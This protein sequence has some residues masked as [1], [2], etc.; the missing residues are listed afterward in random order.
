MP[1]SSRPADLLLVGPC[2]TD[3]STVAY[4]A[5]TLKLFVCVHVPVPLHNAS[6]LDVANAW[7]FSPDAPSCSLSPNEKSFVHSGFFFCSLTADVL[8]RHSLK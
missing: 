1:L 8:M 4:L 7:S 5:I 6:T 2:D 3:L